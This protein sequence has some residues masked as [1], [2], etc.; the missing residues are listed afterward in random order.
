MPWQGADVVADEAELG[1]LAL[2]AFA[3]A[4]PQI[5]GM[6]LDEPIEVRIGDSGAHGLDEPFAVILKEI[7]AEEQIGVPQDVGE[8]RRRFLSGIER[9]ALANGGRVGGA[10]PRL[11]A[12]LEKPFAAVAIGEDGIERRFLDLAPWTLLYRLEGL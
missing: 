1:I 3:G 9:Q 10:R 7:L 5:G 8:Y 12:R 11:I 6:Q 4:L 2:D